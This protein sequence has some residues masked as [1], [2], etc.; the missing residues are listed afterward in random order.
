[1]IL[2][3]LCRFNFYFEFQG[4]FKLIFI[5]NVPYFHF[6]LFLIIFIYFY[7]SFSYFNISSVFI[8]IFHFLF[9][10]LFFVFNYTILYPFIFD[11]Q[12]LNRYTCINM[13]INTQNRN[14]SRL[15]GFNWVFQIFVF[16]CTFIKQ[17]VGKFCT[18]C[19]NI[20]CRI[21]EHVL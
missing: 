4:T 12:T 1:M 21:K 5:N 19:R 17:I 6:L 8:F 11:F 15:S 2:I 3:Y 10:F 16:F 20:V 9:L 7:F 18:F 13:Y 14:M